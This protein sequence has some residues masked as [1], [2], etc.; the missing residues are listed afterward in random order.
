MSG[1]LREYSIDI[2][3]IIAIMEQAAPAARVLIVD[4][5][6][7]NA[8]AATPRKGGVALQ[9][10]IEDT[11]ILF[12]DEP[13]KTIAARSE[14]SL[15]SPFTAGLLYAFENSDAGIEKRFEIARAK[16]QE[17]SPDQ[18]P[19]MVKSES[20]KNRQR[21]FLDHGGRSAPT[22]SAGQL[23]N[24]AEKLY[25]A[26][27]WKAFQE[28][29]QAARF[30]SSEPDLSSRLDKEME[31]CKLVVSAQEAEADSRGPRWADAATAWQAAGLVFA[32]RAWVI[33]RAA[34]CWL[35]A[36]RMQ[37]AVGMLARLQAYS[38]GTMSNRAAQML[39]VLIQAD[40][41]LEAIARSSLRDVVPHT[42]TEFERYS[43]R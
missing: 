5:C 2:D 33:E 13:G 12:A 24:S 32:E 29:I 26:R 3:R 25:D 28:T 39:A 41:S 15:Q 11:Y 16:T 27:S 10:T 1:A 31:F 36:D 23:L 43:P 38:I 4:A 19:E 30:L 8:F 35:L 14:D 20:S 22:Q 21:P 42:G 6:R 9:S 37:E 17:L 7:N 34:L 40:S 18:H